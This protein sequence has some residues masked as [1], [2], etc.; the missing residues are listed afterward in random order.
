MPASPSRPRS[1]AGRAGGRAMTP[2]GGPAACVA[3][4]GVLSCALL[5]HGWGMWRGPLGRVGLTPPRWRGEEQGE[6]EVREA[7]CR[8]KE[9]A[10]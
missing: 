10:A 2:E 8:R 3:S 1:E 5:W 6:G 7:A 9:T 4:H